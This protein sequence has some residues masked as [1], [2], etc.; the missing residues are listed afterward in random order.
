MRVEALM[1]ATT[2]AFL[3]LG[4]VVAALVWTEV[5]ELIHAASRDRW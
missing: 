2:Y 1:T 3:A 4:A 5:A